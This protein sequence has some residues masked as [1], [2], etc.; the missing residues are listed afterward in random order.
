MADPSHRPY[1]AQSIA[2]DFEIPVKTYISQRPEIFGIVSAAII[3]H[4]NQV[5]LVQRAAADDYPNVWE[6][7]GGAAHE[8]ETI[9]QCAVREMREEVGLDA[10]EI[11]SMIGEFDWVEKNPDSHENARDKERNWKVF[12]FLVTVDDADLHSK[13][14]LDPEEHQ[15]YMWA[16]EAEIRE[17]LCGNIK[18]EW[19]S[20]NQRHA[21]LAAFDMV[22]SNSHS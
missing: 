6:V 4:N 7:P 15:V 16:T 5:L 13:I 1:K 19:I 17:G 11:T 8:D 21:I 20:I 2:N 12:M 22:N 3:I 9:I 14:K 10:S 18:L